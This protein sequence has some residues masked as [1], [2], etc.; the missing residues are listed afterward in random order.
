MSR[1]EFNQNKLDF[2]I[3]WAL[4]ET[5]NVAVDK[6]VEITPRDPQRMPKDPTQEVTWNLKRSI[7]YEKVNDFK[8]KVWT[9]MSDVE[10]YA[11][12]MEFWT[13]NIPARPFLR[14]WI[15]D[16]LKELERNFYKVTNYFLKK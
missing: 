15:T 3:K 9:T 12:V 2:A 8:Y 10:S 11:G 4:K 1:V 5:C 13:E 7:W 16:N 6:I 14:K